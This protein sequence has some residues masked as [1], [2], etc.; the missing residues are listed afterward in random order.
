M[1][2]SGKNWGNFDDLLKKI[3]KT[4]ERRNKIFDYYGASRISTRGTPLNKN[5]LDGAVK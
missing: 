5:V 4:I 1:S 3:L 2:R